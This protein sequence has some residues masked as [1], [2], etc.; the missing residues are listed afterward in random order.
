MPAAQLPHDEAARLAALRETGLV[1]S[2]PPAVFGGLV[3]VARELF[4]AP[5]AAISLIDAD[6]QWFKASE[7]LGISETPRELS[8]CA[9][10]ILS[11]DRV[12]CVPDAM[13][14]PRF[15][16]NALVRG[17]PHIRFY[18][19]APILDA[20]GHAL[21]AVCVIDSR[22][23]TP[24]PASLAR[25]RDLAA[26]VSAAVQLHT[27]R[28]H[29][30]QLRTL[31]QDKRVDPLTGVP[32]RAA[33]ERALAAGAPGG[34]ALL[35][36]DLDGLKG[37]NDLFG[38]RGGDAALAEAGRRL[39]SLAPRLA[40]FRLD[41][42]AFALLAAP[43]SGEAPGASAASVHAVLSGPFAIDGQPVALRASIGVAAQAGI[44]PAALFLQADIALRAA[45]RAGGHQ[46]RHAE[47]RSAGLAPLG[48]IG[49]S[50]RL[51]DALVPPGREP[52]TLVFQPV[53][54]LESGATTGMEAL[55]RWQP[56]GAET[57]SPGEFVLLAERIG[58]VSHLDRWVLG[59][60]CRAAA[61]W[62]GPWGVSV[63]ISAMSFG[64]IDVAALVADAL[65]ASGLE[66][67]RLTIEMTE[68]A[69]AREPE[70]T[71]QAVV[72]LRALGVGVA[73]D[74]FGAGHGSLTTLRR[75]PFSALKID[76]GLIEGIV[77]DGAQ[78]HMVGMVTQ[79][80]HKLGV[81]VVAEGVETREELATVTALGATHVQGRLLS[82]PVP[83]REVAGAA[84]TAEAAL[85]FP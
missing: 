7:G 20:S 35:L 27:I 56:E 83:G 3:R 32:G 48:R 82:W 44:T 6:R 79:L 14:D 71:R 73:L 66:A 61:A 74:D 29:G 22:P 36:L 9:H 37:L 28:L 64:L 70:R 69:L 59:S 62:A 18:A 84:L 80:G 15:A 47:S 57:V 39:A 8:F 33:F 81:P 24:E 50:Q 43:Q 42:D 11:P 38:H 53:V 25:L 16:G 30:K 41:A 67:G 52:F 72:G 19:G 60:A 65:A 76:R 75:F 12:T 26:G 54:A 51:R 55:V 46:T 5:I 4:A 85:S 58:L 68:T 13:L 10:A 1:D 78:A 34:S 77:P 2:Q 21:G 31:R 17:D 23:H 49:L 63:N 40:A 45:K